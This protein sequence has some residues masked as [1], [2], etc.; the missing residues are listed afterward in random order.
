MIERINLL[1]FKSVPDNAIKL[2]NLSLFSGLNNSGKSSVIQAV[3]MFDK[4]FNQE[5]PLLGGH[6]K[7]DELR[8][9]SSSKSE[10]LKISFL[11]DDES[12][13]H[14]S[15]SNHEILSVPKKCPIIGYIGAD[16]LGPQTSLPVNPRLNP[17]PIIGDKGEYVLDF[18]EKLSLG[19]IPPKLRHENAQGSTFEYVLAGWL[20][21]IA[22]DLDFKYNINE[23]ADLAHAE[24][25]SFR[26]T[27]VGFGISYTLPILAM[28]L[29]MSACA[30]EQGW[31]E[32]W[33]NK[34]EQEKKERGVLIMLENPEA[35][36]HP[37][38]QTAIGKMLALAASC[39]IQIIV[40]THSDHLM[41]GIRI[42]V[43][44]GDVKAD[45]VAFHFF[46]K[47]DGISHIESPKLY[48]DGK[49]DFWPDGFFDQSL[50]NRAIL[51]KRT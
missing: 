21:E 26:P 37:R 3:R 12:D 16:R 6:G 30:P 49:L 50:K 39:G 23:K 40:E 17:F 44:N 7:I 9:K 45:Q 22:P 33:G 29:G 35:H 2:S 38:G 10:N 13:E 34:W 31:F 48:E 15:L 18:I 5:S 46:S 51:A 14:L 4:A 28:V 32:D 19:I 47:I 20:S 27:N 42:A 1:N 36:L 43:K 41:D 11:F 25:D 8:S 24:V